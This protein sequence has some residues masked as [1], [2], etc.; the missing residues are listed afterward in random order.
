MRV[1]GLRRDKFTVK[2]I[3]RGDV[4]SGECFVLVPHRDPAAV[5]ALRTYARITPDAVLA[6]ELLVWADRLDGSESSV[7]DAILAHRIGLWTAALTQEVK[8]GRMA[9]ETALQRIAGHAA[10]LEVSS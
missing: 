7:K 10:T 6:M 4:D 2:H 8:S 9:I 1:S 3:S 5:M